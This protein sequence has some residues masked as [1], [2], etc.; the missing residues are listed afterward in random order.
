LISSRKA[1]GF[2]KRKK[3]IIFLLFLFTMKAL[4]VID[5]LYDFSNRNGKLYVAG[6][7]RIIPRIQK[8]IARF[9][10]ANLPVFYICDAHQ[11]NDSEF[12]QWPEHAVKG[13]KG[14]EVIAALK[15]GKDDI[16][17]E[18]V[19][20]NG[21][22]NPQLDKE[23]KKSNVDELYI[24]GVA[25]EYCVKHTALDGLKKGYK[26]KVVWNCIKEV[27]KK[28]GKKALKEIKQKGGKITKPRKIVKT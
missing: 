28:E 14:A 21:F 6:A 12:K 4:F 11:K 1:A 20:Y 18:K 8:L 27:D 22:S 15:P 19:T 2:D 26:V 5:M 10:K 7:E 13:T 16:V 9:R 17:I 23:L 25:T 24:T 3:F